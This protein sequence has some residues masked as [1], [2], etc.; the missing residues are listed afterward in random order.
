[1]NDTKKDLRERYW[2]STRQ[3]STTSGRPAASGGGAS[4]ASRIV[5]TQWAPSTRSSP[6]A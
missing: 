2:P 4:A 6:A 1:M 5:K 3:S